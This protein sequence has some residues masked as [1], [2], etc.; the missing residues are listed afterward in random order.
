MS[1]KEL[2][3]KLPNLK[4]E[5]VEAPQL[6]SEYIVLREKI[7]EEKVQEWEKA[8]KEIF[9][10]TLYRFM[11]TT[12]DTIKLSHMTY[13]D[14]LVRTMLSQE[15]ISRRFGKD[16]VMRNCCVDAIL[17]TTDG[18]IVVGIKKNSV[19][20]V[21]GKLGYIGGNMNADEV[22]VNSFENICT[23]MMK[24]IEE[25]SNIIPERE[26]LSFAQ[27]GVTDTW[28][29]F[30]FVYRLNVSSKNVNDIYKDDEFS[31]FVAMTPDEIVCADRLATEDLN[32]SKEWIKEVV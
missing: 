21:Q 28:A 27:L 14:R 11:G 7:W 9:N 29:S 20:L 1:E 12:E 17:I 24:E 26:C 25:E 18:K 8:G 10:G 23:M 30:Y 15:E 19:D 16:H 5:I 31:Q 4:I 32:L 3:T 2:D 22:E 13:A 6:S